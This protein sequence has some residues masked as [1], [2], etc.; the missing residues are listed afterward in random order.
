MVITMA[1]AS[2][3]R[4]KRK[5]RSIKNGFNFPEAIDDDH[6]YEEEDLIGSSPLS[7]FYDLLLAG[8]TNDVLFNLSLRVTINYLHALS[9]VSNSLSISVVHVNAYC[10]HSRERQSRF[11]TQ[12]SFGDTAVT[13][14]DVAAKETMTMTFC[15][16]CWRQSQRRLYFSKWSSPW[17]WPP[18]KGGS[19]KRGH[20]NAYLV[21]LRP[22]TM[23]I[24]LRKMNLSALHHFPDFTTSCWL[25][26]TIVH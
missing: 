1:L 4:R 24:S 26:H 7:R 5:K 2:R 11:E 14:A 12:L 6:L 23:S 20:L 16:S 8:T 22:L 13:V 15:Q 3:K 10:Y 21:I 17:L 19:G 9:N 18:E 25:V